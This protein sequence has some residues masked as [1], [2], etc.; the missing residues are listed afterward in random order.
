MIYV[1]NID[2]RVSLIEEVKYWDMGGR[3]HNPTA[4]GKKF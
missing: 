4:H 2:G 3:F 1:N